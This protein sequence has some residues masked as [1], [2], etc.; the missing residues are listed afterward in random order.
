MRWP[1]GSLGRCVVILPTSLLPVQL[2]TNDLL[3]RGA[4]ERRDRST[5]TPFGDA[6][7]CPSY[8]TLLT[9]LL[10]DSG[11]VT[12]PGG[13]DPLSNRYEEAR[14][15]FRAIAR[16]CRCGKCLGA[17]L[18]FDLVGGVP[19]T[20]IRQRHLRTLEAGLRLPRGA[21]GSSVMAPGLEAALDLATGHPDR[22]NTLV[23]LTDFE[24]L[25]PEPGPVL[26]QLTAFPGQV[27]AVVLGR[28]LPEGLLDPRIQ[29]TS[30]RRGDPP[31]TLARTVFDSLTAHRPGALAA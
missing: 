24:L 3:G 13:N 18:H 31:G 27:H 5:T 16:A 21:V 11:S 30:I 7:N 23:V 28:E 1:Q 19:P 10:D 26:D 2:T 22:L 15:A 14:R 9:M 12:A 20:P 25:D 29:V 17:V 4:P 8:S 6:G